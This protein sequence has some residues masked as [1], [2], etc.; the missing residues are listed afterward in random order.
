[1]SEDPTTGQEPSGDEGHIELRVD[2]RKALWGVV[3]VLAVLVAVEG[4]ALIRQGDRLEKL[5]QQLVS[6]PARGAQGQ[7]GGQGR[8]VQQQGNWQR[9]EVGAGEGQARQGAGART[10][11]GEGSTGGGREA[12]SAEGGLVL[13]DQGFRDRKAEVEQ[14]LETYLGGAA[15]E[16]AVA[17]A[18]RG[19]VSRSFEILTEGRKQYQAEEITDDERR[20]R[21]LDERDR[22]VLAVDEHVGMAEATRFHEQVYGTSQLALRQHRRTANRKAKA[23]TT[24]R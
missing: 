10:G 8:R 6:R 14:N 3:L 19:E 5:E 24:G 23:G 2:P 12:Q 18:L 20:Q 21:L 4:I 13:D 1:M 16:P 9:V 17:D 11:A 15:L 22:M 7:G